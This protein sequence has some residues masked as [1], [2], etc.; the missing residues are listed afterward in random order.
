MEF[1]EKIPG[2]G[3]NKAGRF[4]L[5]WAGARFHNITGGPGPACLLS[6]PRRSQSSPGPEAFG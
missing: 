1:L 3:M 4:S 2:G 5:G 6:V